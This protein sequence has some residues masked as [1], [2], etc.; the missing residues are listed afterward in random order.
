MCVFF[1]RAYLVCVGVHRSWIIHVGTHRGFL[2]RGEEKCSNR[3][4]FLCSD[5]HSANYE[6]H[7]YTV[8]LQTKYIQICA[9]CPLQASTQQFFHTETSI[10][11]L[12]Q[13]TGIKQW[14]NTVSVHSSF[15]YTYMCTLSTCCRSNFLANIKNNSLVVRLAKSQTATSQGPLQLE[16]MPLETYLSYHQADL[17]T[18]QHSHDLL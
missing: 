7:E 9:A 5:I 3:H 12:R 1:M 17:P 11:S 2:T 10:L 14:S 8:H 4:E 16:Q 15:S 13:V 6:L 18:I